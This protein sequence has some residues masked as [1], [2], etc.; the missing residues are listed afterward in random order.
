MVWFVVAAASLVAGIIQAVTGF[1]SVVFLMMIL[2]FYFDMIDAPALAIVVNQLFCMA[3]CWK[4]RRHIQWRV[5]LPPTI[6]FGL[7]NLLIMPFVSRLVLRV[8][9]LIFAGFLML[10][11]LYFLVVARR[12]RIA[13]KPAV[14]VVCGARLAHTVSGGALKKMVSVVCILLGA[15]IVI[16]ALGQF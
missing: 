6:A 4:Y 10:L 3:L 13:P 7:A 14:G 5:A 15:Y 1:G 12:I 9:V 2:P 8:L 16:R 11:A